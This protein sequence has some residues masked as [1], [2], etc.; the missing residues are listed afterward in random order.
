MWPG[1]WRRCR[2]IK[3]I[4]KGRVVACGSII[5]A[6][7]LVIPPAGNGWLPSTQPWPC[8]WSCRD[9]A[10]RESAGSLSRRVSTTTRQPAQQHHHGPLPLWPLCPQSPPLLP[11]LAGLR[12]RRPCPLPVPARAAR[13]H[14]QP[15][16]GGSG[17]GRCAP[18]WGRHRSHHLLLC[19]WPLPADRIGEGGWSGC[20]R[21][22]P[23]PSAP[24]TGGVTP[25]PTEQ[26]VVVADARAGA[27]FHIRPGEGHLPPGSRPLR[28][29][30]YGR[31]VVMG[32]P[33]LAWSWPHQWAGLPQ[34]AAWPWR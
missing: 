34:S 3:I 2:A 12:H 26:P 11:G 7:F 30:G 1:R 29:W 13:H 24:G 15:F 17:S 25:L 28:S 19:G 31:T 21:R 6:H 16:P 18:G 10:V 4:I 14:H 27:G 22:R 33:A 8:M 20:R 9:S 32:E 23:V 5:G